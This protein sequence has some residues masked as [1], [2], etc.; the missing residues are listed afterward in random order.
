MPHAV[1]YWRALEEDARHGGIW[2]ECQTAGTLLEP[3]IWDWE[4]GCEGETRG[5]QQDERERANA[6]SQEKTA[7]E[8]KGEEKGVKNC[9]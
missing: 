5:K 6:E 1:H 3:K 8:E 7:R 4:R 2:A 9:Q